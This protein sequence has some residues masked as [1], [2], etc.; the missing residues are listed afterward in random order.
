MDTDTHFELGC[1]ALGVDPLVVTP[2]HIDR[3]GGDAAHG[4]P[5]S[6]ADPNLYYIIPGVLQA[7][8]SMF[9]DYVRCVV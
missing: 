1:F 8:A 2:A 7:E 6:I 3:Q 9:Q 5:A 4:R